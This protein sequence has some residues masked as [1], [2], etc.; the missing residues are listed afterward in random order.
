MRRPGRAVKDGK[1]VK[2]GRRDFFGLDDDLF[3]KRKYAFFQ[4]Q[5]QIFSRSESTE[6]IIRTERDWKW[7]FY[8]LEYPT[9][10][11]NWLKKL[12]FTEL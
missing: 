4:L 10:R 1:W 6:F 9:D 8:S 3:Y 12:I 7:I 11:L 5:S 2:K